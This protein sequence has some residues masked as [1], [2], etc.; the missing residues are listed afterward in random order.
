MGNTF[1]ATAP[2][3]TVENARS[4]SIEQLISWLAYS[5]C[6][7][8]KLVCHRARQILILFSHTPFNHKPFRLPCCVCVYGACSTESVILLIRSRARTIPQI[9]W[10]K[11]VTC[12]VSS[13]GYSV[14]VCVCVVGGLQ[15]LERAITTNGAT[16]TSC[17]TIPRSLDGRLQVSSP[18]HLLVFSTQW[19]KIHCLTTHP[20]LHLCII[21]CWG[22][23]QNTSFNCYNT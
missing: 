2:T 6:V 22:T 5:V 14:C 23:C 19:H 21:P 11:E 8:G 18:W 15:E 16:P 20:P 4:N 17:V 10:C 13:M 7:W 12:R 9:I 1:V 3:V